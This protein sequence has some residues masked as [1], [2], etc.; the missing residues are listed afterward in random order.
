MNLGARGS[1]WKSK[2]SKVVALWEPELKG[3][4]GRCMYAAGESQ[5]QELQLPDPSHCLCVLGKGKLSK[6]AA[7]GGGYTKAKGKEPYRD[8]IKMLSRDL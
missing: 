8:A 1:F 6:S 4:V 2:E 3:A 7:E 5:G